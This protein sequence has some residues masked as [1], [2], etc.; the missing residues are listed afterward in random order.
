MKAF[1]TASALFLLPTAAFAEEQR[2]ESSIIELRTPQVAESLWQDTALIEVRSLKDVE[3]AIWAESGALWLFT[4]R[5][6]GNLQRYTQ[7]AV[8]TQLRIGGMPPGADV[9]VW[10]FSAQATARFQ[11]ERIAVAWCH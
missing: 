2:Q 9:M 5:N 3:S 8:C 6:D 10:W 11:L 1:F 7:L 4:L